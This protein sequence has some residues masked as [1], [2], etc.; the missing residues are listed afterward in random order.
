MKV[1][2][3]KKCFMAAVTISLSTSI[4]AQTQVGPV[5]IAQLMTGWGSDTFSLSTGSTVINPAGCSNTDLY[6][7]V[8]TDP[9]YKTYYA[10]ALTAFSM[11]SPV[12]V[13]VNNTQCSSNGRPQ[14]MG[15]TI[16][17]Q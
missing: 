7:S 9:G 8:G 13:I 3:L 5:T 12:I 14:L 4:F 17:K 10:A 15:L 2:L 11:S 16:V 1:T 6:S